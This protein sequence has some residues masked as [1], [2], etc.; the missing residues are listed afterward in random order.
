SGNPG[1]LGIH[2]EGPFISPERPGVHDSATIRRPTEDDFSVLTSLG[3]GST[4]VTL[5]PECVPDGFIRRLA[6]A[7][8]RVSLGHSMATY[9][10]TVRAL[11]DGMT[12]FTHLFNAMRPLASRDPGPIAAALE[13]PG[14]WYG[15]IA[16]GLHV[17][18][19]MLRLAL[20]GAGRAMLVTDAMPPVGGRKDS[21]TLYGE[22][23]AVRNGRLA[24]AD[25][26]LA[27]AALDMAS[28]VRNAVALAGAAL[29]DALRMASRHP[30][31]FLG[32]ADRLGRL[33]PGYRADLVAFMPEDVRVLRT[34]VAGNDGG[35]SASISRNSASAT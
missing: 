1:I 35:Q 3:S 18:P 29:P 6:E 13:T 16:D 4:L 32:I 34:W 20:R 31:E 28:A 33:A 21:F 19:A 5:A 10:E 27:G 22:T 8:V 17:H 14:C 7:G 25:G 2:L 30:A 23:V 12:G 11:R 15:L 26:T 24:R 9:G